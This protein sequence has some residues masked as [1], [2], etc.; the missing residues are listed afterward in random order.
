MVDCTLIYTGEKCCGC[1]LCIESCPTRAISEVVKRLSSSASVKE[2]AKPYPSMSH[3][4]KEIH[5]DTSGSL[6]RIH[7]PLRQ[8]PLSLSRA[9]A[10][11]GAPNHLDQVKQFV[12]SLPRGRGRNHICGRGT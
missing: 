3:V 7:L 4:I 10:E 9:L 1:G 5:G 6:H 2:A 11:D 12:E 8:T